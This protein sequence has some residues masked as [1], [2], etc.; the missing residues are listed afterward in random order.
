MTN[1][2]PFYI[3]PG[4]IGWTTDANTT[5]GD[6]AST[7]T[8]EYVIYDEGEHPIFPFLIDNLDW[9]PPQ[10]NLKEII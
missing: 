4:Y 1:Y 5:T 2:E 6:F 7:Y 10:N 8:S 3:R 9:D